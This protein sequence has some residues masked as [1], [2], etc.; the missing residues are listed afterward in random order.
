M[1][2]SKMVRRT[3]GSPHQRGDAVPAPLTTDAPKWRES[4]PEESD[5]PVTP[6]R[7]R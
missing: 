5:H 2:V 7:L 3:N 4:I 1:V 6:Y